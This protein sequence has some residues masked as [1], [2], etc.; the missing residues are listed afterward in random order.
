M[1]RKLR[2]L[3]AGCVVF[4][5]GA[6]VPRQRISAQNPNSQSPS[7]TI[8]KTWDD[9]A[10]ATLEL[11][12]ADPTASPKQVSG[13]YYYKTPIRTIYKQYPVYA[14]GHEPPGYLD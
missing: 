3:L 11:P 13:D 1:N 14:P 9:A 8:P 4:A 12:L 5:A 10:M 6:T 2:A 7:P